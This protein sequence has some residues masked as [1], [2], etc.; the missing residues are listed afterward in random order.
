MIPTGPLDIEVDAGSI[1]FRGEIADFYILVSLSGTPI[2]AT[3][4]A[5]LYYEG[6]LDSNLTGLIQQVTTGLYRIPY[7]IP[8]D[9]SPG[10]YALV[11]NA[12]RDYARGTA[13][14]TFLISQTLTGW[15]A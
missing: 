15:N 13:L 10:T 5:E 1:H 11:V 7:T 8:N 3:L 14:K 12:Y 2:D 4:T 6:L 9:A